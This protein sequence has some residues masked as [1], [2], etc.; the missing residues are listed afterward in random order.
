M[1][2]AD[3]GPDIYVPRRRAIDRK[4]I[5]LDI[6]ERVRAGGPA[7]DLP[8]RAVETPGAATVAHAAERHVDRIQRRV[9]PVDRDIGDQAAE[10]EGA[11][12]GVV[13]PGHRP[14]IAGPIGAEH[15]TKGC[16]EENAGRRGNDRG[17]KG[18]AATVSS[19]RTGY[20]PG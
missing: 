18:I 3:I 5:V 13:E 4:R 11:G 8:F 2:D 9:V 12:G 20:E 14:G 19:L 6:E 7:A 17:E 10:A 16:P 1:P 15:V